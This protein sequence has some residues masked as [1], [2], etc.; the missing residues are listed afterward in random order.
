MIKVI[1]VLSRRTTNSKTASRRASR[2][3]REVAQRRSDM[4][5]GAAGVFARKG[6]D[7]AQMAEIA[8]EA[9]VSLASL[10]A[11]FRGKDEIYQAVIDDTAERMFEVLR[12]RVEAIEDASE[13]VLVLID[14]LFEC[15]AQDI[16]IL[17][18]VLSGSA[19]VPWRIRA[20]RRSRVADELREWVTELCR[21]AVRR[22]A[23]RGLDGGALSHA[24]LGGVLQAAAHSIER[25]PERPLTDV[26]PRLRAV[27]ER[28]LAGA[29]R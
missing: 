6:Y 10:Y 21:K 14:T 2:R 22:G 18:L 23:L 26:T 17:R 27:F 25:E 1:M 19:G 24:L 13:A 9:E 4:L 7:G 16:A 11:E 29:V 15:L 3:A 12:S 20:D 8:A 5:A 28:L